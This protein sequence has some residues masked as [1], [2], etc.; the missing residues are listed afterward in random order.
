MDRTVNGVHIHTV[1]GEH[2]F[3]FFFFQHGGK[4]GIS[5]AQCKTG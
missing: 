3:F 2:L 1:K 5:E 4:K